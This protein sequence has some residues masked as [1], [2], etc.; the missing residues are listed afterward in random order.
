MA[1]GQS[2]GRSSASIHECL[3]FISPT[4]TSHAFPKKS[5]VDYFFPWNNMMFIGNN[6]ICSDMLMDVPWIY[7]SVSG[8]N[9]MF[10]NTF[11]HV[12]NLYNVLI[13][14]VDINR[15]TVYVPEECW[16]TYVVIMKE[17]KGRVGY[18]DIFVDAC[19]NMVKAL[20]FIHVLCHEDNTYASRTVMRD[21]TIRKYV[22]DL[23]MIHD[24]RMM[25]EALKNVASFIINGKDETDVLA[26]KI[27][28]SASQILRYRNVEYARKCTRI[29][30][31]LRNVSLL[32]DRNIS[33]VIEEFLTCLKQARTDNEVD[34]CALKFRD[35]LQK[36]LPSSASNVINDFRD[37]LPNDINSDDLRVENGS[38]S[39][40]LRPYMMVRKE[41]R[42]L[43]RD[44]AEYEFSMNV[45]N[46]KYSAGFVY[47]ATLYDL[48]AAV[49]AR[50]DAKRDA[51]TRG[52]SLEQRLKSTKIITDLHKDLDALNP[53]LRY[54]RDTITLNDFR[55]AMV[56]LDYFKIQ[57]GMHQRLVDVGMLIQSA[58]A[59]FTVEDVKTIV[60][61]ADG[62]IKTFVKN[63]ETLFSFLHKWYNQA[64]LNIPSRM[65]VISFDL[66]ENEGVTENGLWTVSGHT[67]IPHL[68]VAC[69]SDYRLTIKPVI[70]Y[71]TAS[72]LPAG[73]STA[74][75]AL[76]DQRRLRLCTIKSFIE[77][78]E[79]G[80]KLLSEL[81]K[82]PNLHAKL[83]SGKL[84][85]RIP[86]IRLLDAHLVSAH[87]LLKKA[88]GDLS[89]VSMLDEEE[90]QACNL[91]LS[92]YPN[93]VLVDDG[94]GD[95]VEQ[96][97]YTWI[98]NRL[99]VSDGP[100]R[101]YLGWS[102]DMFKQLGNFAEKHNVT[103]VPQRIEDACN[104]VEQY[105][106]YLARWSTTNEDL[107][108]V[109]NP[110]VSAN[111][112]VF[113]AFAWL[114]VMHR[115]KQVETVLSPS[116]N[117]GV[118]DMIDAWYM[119]CTQFDKR[120]I[121]DVAVRNHPGSL[122]GLAVRGET[123]V[124]NL[125]SNKVNTH[126]ILRELGMSDTLMRLLMSRRLSADPDKLTCAD[127]KASAEECNNF[128]LEIY[129]HAF[130][131]LGASLFVSHKDA[132]WNVLGKGDEDF[133]KG[134]YH[135][136]CMF[137]KKEKGVYLTISE[138]VRIGRQYR[139]EDDCAL[140]SSFMNERRTMP[141][142]R[143]LLLVEDGAYFIA[144][145]SQTHSLDKID[146]SSSTVV[147]GDALN[148]KYGHACF[149]DD[150]WQHDMPFTP[151]TGGVSS[152]YVNRACSG[153]VTIANS[154]NKL[155]DDVRLAEDQEYSQTFVKGLIKIHDADTFPP[156]NVNKQYRNNNDMSD[157][158]SSNQ[159]N[160]S[161][162]STKTTST[163]DTFSDEGT[164]HIAA[165]DMKV[166]ENV[167]TCAAST[168]TV[169]KIDS[170]N[171]STQTD[172]EG[173]CGFEE[174]RINQG[175][176]DERS[177]H[178]S[179]TSQLVNTLSRLLQILSAPSS[180]ETCYEEVCGDITW[181]IE[182]LRKYEMPPPH[183]NTSGTFIKPQLPNKHIQVEFSHIK[184][185]SG[186]RIDAQMYTT[187]TDQRLTSFRT[188]LA[189]A[190]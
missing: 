136:I 40:A 59:S 190:R 8:A 15:V 189:S 16:S 35:S 116:T 188:L 53:L 131:T 108:T 140:L 126:D 14:H 25:Q 77:H 58:F 45:Y 29:T 149:K 134:F 123:A 39:E 135:F 47:S 147:L 2:A 98:R 157:Y 100:N 115:H 95:S 168:M 113:L 34:K 180:G 10:G 49:E 12:C 164:P 51:W 156:T 159:T 64:E 107:C 6:P 145:S 55:Q 170:H 90:L 99:N 120:F 72:P 57:P 82:L 83:L 37:I 162:L 182:Q 166:I 62:N 97:V 81:S 3:S 177:C 70:R 148:L 139:A 151:M 32:Y 128:S 11:A 174:K 184:G 117:I 118:Q 181:V 79:D 92:S 138:C 74:F 105:M 169:S 167:E 133:S 101:C 7:Q 23:S 43:M 42:Q 91:T 89:S 185:I 175:E 48:Q 153:D 18:Y 96:R 30:D 137:L 160:D 60:S 155:N 87:S 187:V 27:G 36:I 176:G 109:C 186:S 143:A 183:I 86:S 121:K 24:A 41:R 165:A 125:L 9:G 106:F 22:R 85:S 179:H 1:S 73:K 122:H 66:L 44:V 4:S 93:T 132:D 112:T 114:F 75:V 144:S 13:A 154:I 67:D 129:T 68:F 26:Q 76:A 150:P 152:R 124:A 52:K 141:V 172:P 173:E 130:K 163:G 17:I 161:V 31:Y 104:V 127:I 178:I 111:R 5:G 20:F 33:T 78:Q 69:S 146:T 142:G 158:L 171:M 88:V 38:V 19:S 71:E 61:A 54:A 103:T 63:C 21:R 65:E 28:F 84:T 46:G 80:I 102:R 94:F 50:A 56:L 110:F 119:W